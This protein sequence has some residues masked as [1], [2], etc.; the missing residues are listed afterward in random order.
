MRNAPGVFLEI[1]EVGRPHLAQALL[2]GPER[3]LDLRVF[4]VA[5]EISCPASIPSDLYL[6]TGIFRR[7]SV[8]CETVPTVNGVRRV[9]PRLQK[10]T[11]LLDR[12]RNLQTVSSLSKG[13]AVKRFKPMRQSHTKSLIG[14][15]HLSLPHWERLVLV[16]SFNDNSRRD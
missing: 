1:F 8:S 15:A 16:P 7:L 14:I 9:G 2:P 4:I 5:D 10:L 3:M 13:Y 12:T 11:S 6:L